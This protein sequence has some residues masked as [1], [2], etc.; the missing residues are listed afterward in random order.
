MSGLIDWL[1]D[2]TGV[3]N[4]TRKLL[5][6]PIPGGARWRYVWGS[7]LVFT[8]F[9]QVVTG[10]ALWACYSPSVQH[11]WASVFYVENFLPLG[12]IVRGIHHYAAQ[13]MVILVI[14]HFV[15]VIVDGAYRAPR[16]FN[17]WLGLGLM[18]IVLG[19]A[20][21]G[22]LLPW[23]QK[24]Y[25]A[26]QVAT[27]IMGTTPV[28]GEALQQ[29]VQGGRDYGQY[30]L[31]RFFA[32]HA[33]VLPA[34][35]V[36]LLTLHLALFRR[37]GITPAGG[38]SLD[39]RGVFWPDQILRDG[40]A[41]AAV[42]GIV[43]LLAWCRPAE[44]SA[45][46]DA[47]QPFAAVRP[48]WYFLSLFRFLKF[49]AVEDWGLAFGAIVVP[50]VIF[51]VVFVM[52]FIARIPGGH[53][54]NVGFCILLIGAAAG[55]TGLALY[56]DAHDDAHQAALRMAWRDADR[57]RELA[58]RRS[59]VPVD[60]AHV[61]LREDPL[62]QGP[63]L[64]AQ[65]CASCHHYNG[66]NG[67]GEMVMTFDAETGATKAVLPTAADLGNLGT[68]EWMRAVIVDFSTLFA[69][70]KNADWYGTADGMDPEESEMTDWSGDHDSLISPDN[71]ANLQALVEF[72]VEQTGRSDLDVDQELA[73]RGRAV[74]IEGQWS[75]DLEGT[76]C[77]DCHETLGT[78]FDPT[79]DGT[80]SDYPE[81]AGYLSAAW[82]QDFLVNPGDAQ[83]YGDRNHMPAYENVLSREELGLLIRWLTGDYDRDSDRE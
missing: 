20:L 1:D 37:H 35:L 34:G 62:T 73:D 68:R 41:C 6:E 66:H 50:G 16:E 70:V 59:L 29:M 33:G 15:Q 57:A 44:L 3:R 5:F 77:A 45:P 60:G 48:E 7:T 76:S 69:P 22:Y 10:F 80:D 71:A 58:S 42:L 79:A 46:A 40:L 36:G 82:L 83:Y 38:R 49:E 75:G 65:H 8:F 47:A 52:P 2:R 51:G 9:V 78:T 74:A 30:T 54:F 43:L 18:M 67:L 61:L 23:D 14:V 32:L 81:I 53:A 12:S 19:L 64:F 39:E 25:Y 4:L 31:T 11:A 56:E 26:T 13:A 55:L 63:R 24:G 27:K 28:I 17:F 21:T 72:M